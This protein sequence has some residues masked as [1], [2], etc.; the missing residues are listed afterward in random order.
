VTSTGG[1]LSLSD[2]MNVDFGVRVV[3]VGADSDGDGD[4]GGS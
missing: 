1:P 2:F 4:G 3:S